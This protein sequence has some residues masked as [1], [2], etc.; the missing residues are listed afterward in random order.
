MREQD[1]P[2]DSRSLSVSLVWK[3]NNRISITDKRS[4][5]M[6]I[7][8]IEEL[9]F[10]PLHE[11]IIQER[12]EGRSPAQNRL[13]FLWYKEAAEQ[14]KD[15][16]REGYRAFCKL[17]IGIPILREKEEYRERYDKFLRPLT[18][19]QKIAMMIDPFNL[20]VTSIMSVK[21][22]GRYLDAIYIHFT[23]L[24]VKLSVPEDLTREAKF[25]R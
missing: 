3:M 2:D 12:E 13:S 1:Q 21:E 7:K 22:K 15:D 4:M 11:V 18:Y 16:T 23:S 25:R 10:E 19:E 6:A 8:L 5:I 20:P 9:P 24:G 17:C 14:R